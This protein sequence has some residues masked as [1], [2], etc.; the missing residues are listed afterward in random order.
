MDLTRFDING[1]VTAMK[2]FFDACVTAGLFASVTLT[3]DTDLTIKD[4]NSNT[5]CTFEFQGTSTDQVCVVTVYPAANT[6]AIPSSAYWT[7]AVISTAYLC[8]NGAYIEFYR[9]ANNSRFPIIMAKTNRGRLAFLYSMAND[10]SSG[11]ASMNYT[12]IK[13]IAWGDETT[14]GLT[15]DAGIANNQTVLCRIPTQAKPLETSYLTDCYR[16]SHA[17]AF[18]YRVKQIMINDK[19]YLTN[20]YYALEIGGAA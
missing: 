16:I 12:S 20:G 4:A 17:P 7:G 14:G 15:T 13:C 8:D 6:A 1:S 18:S 9:A 5:L 11:D 2:E 10:S 19:V 3:D